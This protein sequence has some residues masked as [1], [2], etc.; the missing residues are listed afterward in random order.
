MH[1]RGL[2]EVK[3]AKALGMSQ[4]NFNRFLAG[5]QGLQV[6]SLTRLCI[7]LEMNPVALF[8]AH[9]LYDQETRAKIRFGKDTLYDRFRTILP[10][11]ACRDLVS[12]V[13]EALRLGVYDAVI[14]G[15]RAAIEAAKSGRR[16]AIQE[17]QQPAPRRR[18]SPIG[19]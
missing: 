6:R 9:P 13:E 3:M 7:E 2:S 10:L 5:Q 17:S 8:Q 11:A 16:K 12:L 18:Q 15:A 1:Q 19:T 14:A 4:R